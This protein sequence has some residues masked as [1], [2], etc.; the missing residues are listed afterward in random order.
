MVLAILD[1]IHFPVLKQLILYGNPLA[2]LAIL[3][4]DTSR[5][6]YDPVP[7]L[8][9]TDDDVIRDWTLVLSYPNY[10]KK[11]KFRRSS[12]GHFELATLKKDTIPTSAAFRE[13]GN[14]KLFFH[15]DIY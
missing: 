12:Y 1:A 8:T 7:R 6:A 15:T 9:Y 4:T 3:S 10:S 13:K 5:L 11:K 14:R 2:H